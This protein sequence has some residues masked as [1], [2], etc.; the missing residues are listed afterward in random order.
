MSG[1]SPKTIPLA[2]PLI[3][4]TWLTLAACAASAVAEDATTSAAINHAA[5]AASSE[6]ASG[7]QAVSLPRPPNRPLPQRAAIDTL[8]D[9]YAKSHRLDQRLVHAVIRAE[10]GYNPHAVSPA[11]AIGLMQIMPATAAIYGVSSADALFDANTNLRVGMRHLNLLIGRHGLGKAVMAYNAEEGALARHNG[12]VTYAETQRYTH[13]VLTDYLKSKGIDPYSSK[14]KHLTGISLTPAMATAGGGAASSG[15]SA[16]G[17]SEQKP[18]TPRLRDLSTLST[19]SSRTL[20]SLRSASGNSDPPSNRGL[21]L[22]RP[23]PRR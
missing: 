15:A 22:N 5:R 7:Q 10:S 20:K 3:L 2:P 11:G 19:L 21:Q 6:T 13:R 18:P 8:I 1:A 16:A 4:V 12:F 14:A 17:P 23:A 9:R